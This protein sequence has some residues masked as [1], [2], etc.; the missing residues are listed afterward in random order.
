[1]VF[2]EESLDARLVKRLKKQKYDVDKLLYKLVNFI[3]NKYF[4]NEK[5][6]PIKADYVEKREIEH[7]TLY[8]FDGPFQHLHVDVG[9]LEVLGKNATSPQY[10]LVIVDLFSS[11][12]Y[13]YSMK[14]RR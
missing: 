11:K 3:D 12:I 10:V 9:N 4:F 1:M 6:S 14:S 7:S 13:T 2:A 5:K 8:N